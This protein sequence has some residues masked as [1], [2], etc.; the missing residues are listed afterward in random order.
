MNEEE[1]LLN[2]LS[3]NIKGLIA[4][5]KWQEA[6]DNADSSER[7]AVAELY[8]RTICEQGGQLE[9][10]GW[11]KI[12]SIKRILIKWIKELG[13]RESTNP[14][15][16][17]IQN[18]YNIADNQNTTLTE[19]NCILLNNLYADRV[20]DFADIAGTGENGL[21]HVIFNHNLYSQDDSDAEFIVKAYESL[22]SKSF[23]DRLNFDVIKSKLSQ[24]ST[25][26]VDDNNFKTKR[27]AIIYKEPNKPQSS[28]LNS[29]YYIE[30]LL[31]LG[32]NVSSK[33]NERMS[34]VAK[35]F[36]ALSRDERKDMLKSMFNNLTQQ[37][38][39][40]LVSRLK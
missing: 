28:D 13:F 30:E 38:I 16:Q 14:Y 9:K 27:D 10:V 25:N 33:E 7:D 11:N 6:L 5:N 34:R 29:K 2:S 4:D 37:E 39:D 8:L 17:F 20:L 15:L 3:D 32:E 19:T 36:N 24:S 31:S 23:I 21:N 26:Y 35:D 18:F 40:S 1:K 12:E 22:S